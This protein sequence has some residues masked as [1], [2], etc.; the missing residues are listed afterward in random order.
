MAVHSLTVK[1]ILSR[2][3]QVFPDA[4]EA[5]VISLI[6]DALT[7]A[8]MYNVKT[9]HAKITTVAD[10]M[11]Y[12]LSDEAYSSDGSAYK[13]DLN[14]IFRVYFM[15]SEVAYMQIPRLVDKD[16]VLTDISSESVLESQ[17]TN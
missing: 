12:D 7:E 6:N 15:D 3:R 14:K 10:Q 11:W 1:Q 13:L 2:V 4:P 9:A 8:G 5:Y 16:L 17:D